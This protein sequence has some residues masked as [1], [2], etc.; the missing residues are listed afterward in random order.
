M[1]LS[2]KRDLIPS[3]EGMRALAVLAVLLFHLHIAGFDGGFL[4]VDVF[5]VISGFIITRNILRQ[6]ERG[7]FSLARFYY[8]RFRRLI[9]AL[10]V[11]TLLTLAGAAW[12]LPPADLQAAAQSAVYT[13]L[14][15]SNFLF[16]WQSGYFDAA[17]HTKPLLHTWSLGVEEQFYLFWPVLLL[18]FL[19]FRAVI[20]ACVVL[21]L[22]SVVAGVLLV[23]QYREAVFFLAPFR[24][25]QFMAGAVLAAGAWS[26]GGRLG[27]ALQLAGL[28][29]FGVAVAL[30]N[31]EH[32]PMVGGSLAAG[33]SLL[34]LASRGSP[35]A[36]RVT[37]NPV[38][39]WIGQRSYAIYL[40]H[41]PLIVLFQFRT[42]SGLEPMEQVALGVASIAGAMA[43]H[44]L[45]ERPFRKTS[46]PD[47]GFAARAAAPA[48]VV[49]LLVGMFVAAN[50]WGL[51]GLK[52]QQPEDIRMAVEAAEKA[53]TARESQ[54]RTG[55]CH[56]GNGFE[57][58]Q[59]S[60][61]CAGV[62]RGKVNVLVIGDSVGA[63]MY[64][65]LTKAYPGVAFSQATGGRCPPLAGNKVFPGCDVI[66]DYRFGELVTH[67]YDFVVF[68]SNWKA[69]EVP[70]LAESIRRVQA[71]GRRVVV[72]G[73]GV[74]FRESTIRTLA[75]SPD[76]GSAQKRIQ[77]NA[78]RRKAL[79]DSV[80]AQAAGATFV[81]LVAA[82]CPRKQCD[83]F[84]RG[85][86]LYIDEFHLSPRGAHQ[87]GRNF[88][89]ENPKLF[90][91]PGK[92]PVAAR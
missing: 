22:A 32:S 80:R 45:V 36:T 26:I 12:L 68:A 19:R 72:I 11:V 20:V 89:R 9:P 7:E 14:S 75:M 28:A 60:P 92:T 90:D 67:D 52:G 48:T 5:F 57:L 6:A 29:L 59:Y 83:V 56:A 81:D 16:W 61:R 40:V 37:G 85:E 34:L 84:Q 64:M 73:P 38:L 87:I 41:W 18:L 3:I 82:Q 39:V 23:E 66:N 74:H 58:K 91:V 63:D 8:A 30:V 86:L 15:V 47:V 55:I 79:V 76:F 70:R 2:P 53:F 50:L 71:L 31:G 43:L 46:E 17:S 62:R 77:A 69:N 1:T 21:G 25:Y 35:F 24:V 54:T 88:A 42:G 44:R 13:V 51:G 27:D 78:D 33:A 65:M 10:A 49:M 4:G